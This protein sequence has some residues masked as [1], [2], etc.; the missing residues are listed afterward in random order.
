MRIIFHAIVGATIRRIGSIDG[1]IGDKDIA[2]GRI[3]QESLPPR[4]ITLAAH[5]E[6][7]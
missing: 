4:R 7:I 1:R 2:S 6:A 5:R 3:N